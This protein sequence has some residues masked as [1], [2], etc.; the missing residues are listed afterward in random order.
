MPYNSE[1]I[2]AKILR[3]EIPCKV[4]LENAFGLAFHDIAPQAPLH[5]LVIPKGPFQSSSDFHQ[6]ASPDEIVGFYTFLENVIAHFHLHEEGYRLI[7]NHG[8][9]AG[10]EVPHFHI[11]LLAGQP[12]GPLLTGAPA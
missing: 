12:L 6:K 11:H 8:I 9:N 2:F 1:N 10:Q 5:V 7:S 3:K 4:V